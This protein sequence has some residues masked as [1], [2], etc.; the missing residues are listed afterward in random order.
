MNDL[1][2][3]NVLYRETVD[4]VEGATL[5]AIIRALVKL[6]NEGLVS[7]SFVEY[8]IGA[9]QPCPDVTEEELSEH[10]RGRSEAA[11]RAFP[12]PHVARRV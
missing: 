5:S 1:E 12:E 7:C 6:T 2:P 8:G 11:L 9:K 10:C 4:Q 3:F